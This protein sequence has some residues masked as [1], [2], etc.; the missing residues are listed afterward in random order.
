MFPPDLDNAY[1]NRTHPNRPSKKAE[2]LRRVQAD[3]EVRI[4]NNE[5]AFAVQA[6]TL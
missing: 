4:S 1:Y 2:A 5:G 6:H 3:L